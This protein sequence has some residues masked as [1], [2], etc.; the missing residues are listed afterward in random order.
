MKMATAEQAAEA[1]RTLSPSDI[2]KALR[3]A[4]WEIDALS[5]DQPAEVVKQAWKATAK[6]LEK[7]ADEIRSIWEV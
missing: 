7:T 1:L 3:L 2:A 6:K 4:A 5:T